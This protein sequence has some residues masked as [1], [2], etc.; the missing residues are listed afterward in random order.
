MEDD[1]DIEMKHVDE[2]PNSDCFI[3]L[4]PEEILLHV[5]FYLIRDNSEDKNDINQDF[6]QFSTLRL[7]N[8]RWLRIAPDI[9]NN[10]IKKLIRKKMLIYQPYWKKLQRLDA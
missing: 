10:L 2:Q 1:S 4:L 8:K 7:V 9:L 6:K 3:S 5:F